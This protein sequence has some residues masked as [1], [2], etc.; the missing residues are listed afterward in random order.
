MNK[1]ILYK[2]LYCSCIFESGYSTV[3]LHRTKK[4]AY[5][6]MRK[7]IMDEW[8]K[9]TEIV[10]NFKGQSQYR[11]DSPLQYQSWT[12]EEMEVED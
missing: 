12:V 10:H 8:Y 5:K 1:L 9:N 4:G 11:L 2:V 3:S 6:A 7:H